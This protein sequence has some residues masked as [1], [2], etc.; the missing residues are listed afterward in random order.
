MQD[1][2]VADSEMDFPVVMT[3]TLYYI[4]ECRW[5]TALANIRELDGL[6][7][8]VVRSG[9]QTMGLFLSINGWSDNVPLLLKQ[10]PPKAIMLMDGNDLRIVLRG[11]LDLK[12][13]IRAKA[14]RLSFRG[15]PYYSAE[16]CLRDRVV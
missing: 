6:L 9:R 1:I 16:Q 13:L 3:D 11:H 2:D 15:E 4:V 8:Q 5:R 12:D 14:E 7:G 10:N